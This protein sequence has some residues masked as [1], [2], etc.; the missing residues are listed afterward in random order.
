M[1]FKGK[2]NIIKEI[3][4]KLGLPADG[5]D[6][7][8]TWRGVIAGILE[9]KSDKDL[10]KC[11]QRILKVDD[12]GLPGPITWK[13]IKSIIVGDEEELST[14]TPASG[15]DI[16]SPN[17]FKLILDYEV[18]GGQAYYNKYL[19]KPCWPKGASGVTIG[20]GYDCGYNSESQFEKDWHG[21]ISD[22]D[23]NRLKQTLGY[24]G[25]VASKIVGSVS[26]IVIPWEA[27][28][29]V[30]NQN[31]V[32]RFISIMLRS[33]PGADQLHPDAFG[34][35]LSIVFNRG[36]SLTGSS[37]KEM[38]NIRELVPSKDYKAIANEI[39]SMK[40]L[41]VGKGLD[42]LLRRRDKEAELVEA[43]A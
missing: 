28:L 12:D 27:A 35:L 26:D 7:L 23:Y 16:L 32:P 31:T 29:D 39:R 1:K 9:G 20:I 38:A 6:G 2:E 5:I 33:F 43:C 41:W 25:N 14:Y 10:I 4:T 37:R 40:R 30:F 34:A 17:A 15:D 21:K 36:G 11:V 3:Q 19:R 18:G 24:K 13:T 22:S 42:G 8:N